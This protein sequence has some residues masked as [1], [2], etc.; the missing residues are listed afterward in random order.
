MVHRCI[1]SGCDCIATAPRRFV[2]EGFAVM[3]SD[4]ATSGSL[5]SPGRKQFPWFVCH[6]VW[7]IS[8]N[9]K[10]LGFIPEIDVIYCKK[11]KISLR[12]FDISLKYF[13]LFWIFFSD[14]SQHSA[15]IGTC[16]KLRI[17][18]EKL[19]IPPKILQ[20]HQLIWNR[21]SKPNIG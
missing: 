12:L 11:L 14:S 4:T 21:D 10:F 1:T 19:L 3:H 15:Y 8:S 7:I 16:Q 13:F 17:Y 18:H 9:V 5:S 2:Q 6:V 20:I